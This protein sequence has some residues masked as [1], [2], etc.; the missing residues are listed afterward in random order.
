M[1]ED[2]ELEEDGYPT[3]ETLEEIS[4][5][6]ISKDFHELM[7]FVQDQWHWGESQYSE[8]V[9]ESFDDNKEVTYCFLTGGWSGNESIIEA[10]E[11]NFVFWSL[12]WH[13]SKRGGKYKFK[14]KVPNMTK[15]V[16]KKEQ[17][18]DKI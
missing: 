6:Q 15:D 4:N 16:I 1:E 9:T 3:E 7:Y 10:L 11:Q 17:A 2:F 13:S 12:H 5:W 18:L 8:K 14:I